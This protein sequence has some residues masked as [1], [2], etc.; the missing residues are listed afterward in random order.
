M[1]ENEKSRHCEICGK[2]SVSK[3]SICEGVYYCG[4]EH[5]KVDWKVHKHFF[6]RSQFYNYGKSQQESTVK[7]L[8]VNLQKMQ[9]KLEK[10]N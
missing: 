4:V 5:Q 6:C 2:E 9:D 10:V 8:E 1:N 7:G 3:C